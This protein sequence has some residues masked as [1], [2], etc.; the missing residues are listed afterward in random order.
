MGLMA[1][2]EAATDRDYG[3]LIL[4]SGMSNLT[5]VGESPRL[6]GSIFIISHKGA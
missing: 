6:R 1:E 2:E 4:P 3:S 5:V